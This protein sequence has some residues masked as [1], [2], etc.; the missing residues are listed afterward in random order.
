[1]NSA[2]LILLLVSPDFLASDYCYDVEMQDALERH[3]KRTARVVRVILRPVDWHDAPFSKLQ[4]SPKDGKAIS[5]WTNRDLAYRNVVDGLRSVIRELGPQ[6]SAAQ[7]AISGRSVKRNP[8]G[9]LIRELRVSSIGD[10][11]ATVEWH[12]T[13][14]TGLNVFLILDRNRPMVNLPQNLIQLAKDGLN[15]SSLIESFSFVSSSAMVKETVTFD[16][17]QPGT[18]YW[19][20]AQSDG[21]RQEFGFTTLEA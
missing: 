20:V 7:S 14:K 8:K 9:T 17:L 5:T 21:N 13:V 12:T 10:S 15:S 19:V 16:R 2:K 1:L 6:F 11:V 3:E 4:A 18:S